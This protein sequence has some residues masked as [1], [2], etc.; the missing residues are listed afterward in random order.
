VSY[1]LSVGDPL[2]ETQNFRV[3]RVKP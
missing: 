3:Y 1:E 2:L